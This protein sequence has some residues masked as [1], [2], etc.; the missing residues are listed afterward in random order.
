MALLA[1]GCKFK[2]TSV[3]NAENLP[4]TVTLD[5]SRQEKPQQEIAIRK[6]SLEGVIIKPYEQDSLLIIKESINQYGVDTLLYNQIDFSFMNKSKNNYVLWIEKND[7]SSLSD[8]VK[9]RKYFFTRRGDFSLMGLIWDGNV[10]SFTPSLFDNFM[11]IIKPKEQFIV[12]I[13]VKGEINDEIEMIKIIERQ[14]QIVDTKKI[15]GFTVDVFTE[16][17]SYKSN[18]ITVLYEWFNK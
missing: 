11:K 7:V 6:N 17:I 1:G 13:I 3:A 16:F 5:S 2:T 4:Q 18:N 15:N 10:G 12:S 9:I 8:S 14:I